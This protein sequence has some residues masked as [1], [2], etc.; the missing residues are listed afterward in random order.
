MLRLYSYHSDRP[1][2]IKELGSFVETINL[3]SRISPLLGKLTEPDAPWLYME[4]TVSG[5][6]FR[7]TSDGAKFE[8]H[9]IRERV[10]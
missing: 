2:N 4:D 6:K 10:K 8:F 1:E 3:R 9:Y 7:I 5:E